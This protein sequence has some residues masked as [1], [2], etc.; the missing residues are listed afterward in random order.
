[1]TVDTFDTFHNILV[2]LFRDIMDIEEKA[3]TTEEFRDISNNDMH[4]IE[5]IGMEEPRNM[6]TVAKGLSITVGTL[7]IAIN[8]LV[9]KGYVNRERSER[10]RRVVYIS[11]TEKGQAAFKHHKEFHKNM[12]DATIKGLSEEET[13]VLVKALTNLNTFFREY[14]HDSK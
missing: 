9:K 4:I 3:I 12:I 8:S 1:M 14:N 13:K 6:S 11:L 7:T 2:K 5:A 10:D